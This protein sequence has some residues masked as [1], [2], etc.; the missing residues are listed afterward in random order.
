MKNLLLITDELS[1]VFTIPNNLF[2]EFKKQRELYDELNA[3]YNSDSPDAVSK[4]NIITKQSEIL[5][6]LI[7]TI[8][9]NYKYKYIDANFRFL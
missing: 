7:E 3:N 4:N 2:Y 1:H 6:N 5:E 8:K 9:N